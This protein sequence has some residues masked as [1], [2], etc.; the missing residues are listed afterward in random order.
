L[1]LVRDGACGRQTST[2]GTPLSPC[3]QITTICSGVNFLLRRTYR[4]EV[5]AAYVF[6][7]LAEVQAIT[8]EWLP[9][10]N[11]YRPH[12][13][14]GRIPP[15]RCLPRPSTPSESSYAVCP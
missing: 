12:D 6:A 2:T 14:L 9:T 10:Y 13:S 15:T 7:F 4:E 5:L 11:D 8:D 3:G 1:H